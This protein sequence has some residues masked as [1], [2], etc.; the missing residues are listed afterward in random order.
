MRTWPL[1][2]ELT[3]MLLCFRLAEN[4]MHICTRNMYAIRV[5]YTLVSN[6][7][8]HTWKRSYLD[9]TTKIRKS[10]TS[11][12][13][14]FVNREC[15]RASLLSLDHRDSVEGMESEKGQG[16]FAKDFW[17]WDLSDEKT[18]MV[19]DI[20]FAAMRVSLHFPYSFVVDALGVHSYKDSK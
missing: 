14:S 19:L 17:P 1:H 13:L 12:R 10:L 7:N 11:G 5:V 2:L 8:M 9:P 15:D 16:V 6:L 3:I 4:G 18:E 20:L